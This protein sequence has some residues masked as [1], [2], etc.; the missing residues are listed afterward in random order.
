[1][2]IRAAIAFTLYLLAPS[3]WA[4]LLVNGS[5]ESP[6][7]PVGSGQI[8]SV[9][10]ST[11]IP[12]WT[13][14]GTTNNIAILEQT[15]VFDGTAFNASNGGQSLDLTGTSND[16][17]A[18]GVVQTVNLAGGFYALYFDL[19]NFT[20]TSSPDPTTID[21]YL[22]GVFQAEFSNSGD[23]PGV[24]NWT[25]VSFDFTA[26]PG[27]NTIELRDPGATSDAYSGLDNVDLEPVVPEPATWSLWGAGI[28]ALAWKWRAAPR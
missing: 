17:L 22:N 16:G 24:I 25:S 2:K 21:F 18:R 15:Y 28:L 8:Y 1:M 20:G 26:P 12:G 11:S 3:A 5:F 6:L 13:V 19:G 27:T 10:D 7:I 4:N 14:T 23:T 9:G